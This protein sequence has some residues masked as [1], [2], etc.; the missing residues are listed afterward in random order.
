MERARFLTLSGLCGAS[1]GWA[2][3]SNS[4]A[5]SPAFFLLY[6]TPSPPGA[7]GWVQLEL[8][9]QVVTSMPI[10]ELLCNGRVVA[11]WLR[12]W[13][14]WM[15][16]ALCCAKEFRFVNGNQGAPQSATRSLFSSVT[17]SALHH[18]HK[19]LLCSILLFSCCDPLTSLKLTFFESVSLIC[20]W[21]SEFCSDLLFFYTYEQLCYN[22]CP[23]VVVLQHTCH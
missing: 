20:L 13:T 19:S 17:R 8:C 6:F 16:G 23:H 18:T 11:G 22:I 12:L 7:S 10:N 4:A 5:E 21:Q 1:T 15:C 14:W 9:V 3:V 2:L